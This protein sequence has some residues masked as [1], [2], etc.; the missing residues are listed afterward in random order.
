MRSLFSFILV[1]LSLSAF[2]GNTYTVSGKVLDDH[3]HELSGATVTISDANVGA[4]SDE[5][6]H[7]RIKQIPEGQHRI[8]VSFI[9]YETKTEDLFVDAN[10]K[11]DFILEH[12]LLNLHEVEISCVHVI[13]GCKENSLNV[14]SVG[15][16]FLKQNLGGSL[17][18][19]LERLPGVSTIDIGSGQSKPVIRGLSFNRVV[20]IDNNVKH[21]SQQWGADHGLEVDQYAVD[22][23]EVVKGPASLKYGSDAIGGVI[24]MQAR[25]IPEKRTFGGSIDLTSKSNN[26]FGG[27]SMSLY[28]RINWLYADLRLT[29]ADYGDYK[30]PTDSV[31]IYSYK[32]PLYNNQMRNTAGE[33][34]NGHLAFGLILPEF[35]NIVRLSSVS[36]KNGLFANAHG[37]EPRYIIYEEQ[38]ASD[39]DILYPFQDVKHLKVIN[40]LKWKL[41]D[42]VLCADI[43]YQ[44]NHRQEWSEYTNHGD[45]PPV[46][47]DTL[48]FPE[49]LE[50]EFDKQTY[51]AKLNLDYY[52]NEVTKI[53]AGINSEWQ[54]NQIGGHG[55][56]IPEYKQQ[57]TGIY[58]L[59]KYKFSDRSILQG[60]IRYDY[61]EIQTSK[62]SDWYPT[63]VIEELDTSWQ[64]LQRAYDLRRHFSNTTWSL[65]YAYNTGHWE[66]KANIGKSFRMP[67]AKE[68]A[69]NGINYHQFSYEKG[70]MNL[71]PEVSYQLDVGIEFHYNNMALG[72]TPFFNYFSNYIYLNPT[73]D[74]DR[75]YGVGNQEYV[76]TEA[77]VLRFGGEVHAHYQLL[78]HL[79]FGVIGE[80]VYS[81]QMSGS[82]KGFTLP[83]S[84]PASAILNLKFQK[85][86]WNGLENLYFSID[87]RLTA[88][89]TNIVPPEEITD[90]Y[91]VLNLGYGGIVKFFNQDVKIMMQVKNVL[92]NKYFNHTSFYRLINVPES[93]R[94]FILNITIPIER[95]SE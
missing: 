93:G 68:L 52:V 62:Y 67:L 71:N 55:F 5:K 30:V 33:E 43:A 66:Y 72:M 22:K 28:G 26:N 73:P 11:V 15:D 45:M 41:D 89:Q 95:R 13:Q 49:E 36:S 86:K 19:S 75:N 84:P 35:Q 21:E 53:S 56:I 57:N 83:F 88:S 23:V 20:V 9:G 70:N 4:V 12:T 39:R 69:A 91:N 42:L 10:H 59:A 40:S 85:A 44:H 47:P 7:Y 81:E 63:K 1:L 51:S 48:S 54:N 77:E 78:K 92:N 8:T 61:G 2:S 31:H 32:A 46:F 90:G 3:G 6:G 27:A 87:W 79:Q 94:N 60:G 24:D 29:L 74:I 16:D 50:R 37:R 58:A 76:Y 14:E 80:Y 34:L 38:D 25:N 18:K 64:Y 82:K 17:M 65:G